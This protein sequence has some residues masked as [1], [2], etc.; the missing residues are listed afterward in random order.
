M[1]APAT[2]NSSNLSNPTT[3]AAPRI[4]WR[5]DVCITD[6]WQGRPIQRPPPMVQDEAKRA[7]AVLEAMCER[8]PRGVIL[9]W[10]A[11]VSAGCSVPL[12]GNALS[13]RSEA[14]ADAV[15][16][17]PAAVFNRETRGEVN[18]AFAFFPGAA[19]VYSILEPKC[20]NWLRDR[21]ALR[22]VVGTVEASPAPSLTDAERDAIVAR[23]RAARE[24]LEAE[25]VERE[26]R[27]AVALGLDKPRVLSEAF[28]ARM[29]AAAIYNRD[30]DPL[31]IAA[32]LERSTGVQR[33]VARGLPVE[34][35]N[36]PSGRSVGAVMRK[37]GLFG[38]D[39]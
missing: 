39:A 3:L 35:V 34:G 25:R 24:A 27:I 29:S 23:S 36:G 10:L 22:K 28:Q 6:A 21:G 33:E 16:H 20:R 15:D 8:A 30:R 17:L 18:R 11:G 12:Y 7:L 2:L 13:E 32:R 9:A 14:V 19:D 37:L 26:A 31:V 1:N 4:S 5:L 38:N